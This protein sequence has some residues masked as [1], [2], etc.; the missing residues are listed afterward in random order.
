M[1]KILTVVLIIMIVTLLLTACT[2][3]SGENKGSTTTS[4]ATSDSGGNEAVIPENSKD[5]PEIQDSEASIN[6]ADISASDASAL[7]SGLELSKLGL[8][9]TK[10]DYK[11]LVGEKCKK[12]DGKDYIEIAV[13]KVV[14]ENEDGSINMQTAAQCFIS[15]D[16][17]TVLLRNMSDG[18]LEQ[19]VP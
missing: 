4:T 17:K 8:D 15:F 10:E 3:Q 19:I 12:I 16:G 1:K 2:G 9:G 6:D 5:A 14:K 18:T 13:S 11:Y 7:I